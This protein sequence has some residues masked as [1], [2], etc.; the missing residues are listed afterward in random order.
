M[1]ELGEGGSLGPTLRRLDALCAASE[2]KK[3][4]EDVVDFEHSD[5]EGEDSEDEEQQR[6]PFF[7]QHLAS[8]SALPA[9][10]RGLRR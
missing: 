10:R 7:P 3:E 2:K 8:P 1:S 6:R 5:D 9:R 4:D